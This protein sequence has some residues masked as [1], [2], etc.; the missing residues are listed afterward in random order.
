[1]SKPFIL[2][3]GLFLSGALSV[4]PA[5]ALAQD[6][7]AP[8][9]HERLGGTYAIASVVDV[10]IDLLL[11]NDVLNANPEIRA[12]RDRV[13]APGLKFQVTALVCQVTGGPCTYG[14]RTMKD[15]H[16]HLNITEGEWQAMLADFQRVLNDFRVPQSEQSEL[17]A[18]VESTKADIVLQP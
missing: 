8:T 5:P 9:L 15:S 1:M 10:F 2:A 18:I 13:P 14:G 17:I 6:P 7:P 11:H 16:A 12:A 4:F 3:V